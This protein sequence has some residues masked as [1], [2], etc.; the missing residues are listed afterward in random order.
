MSLP[1]DGLKEILE[2]MTPD[3]KAKLLENY[4]KFT[5]LRSLCEARGYIEALPGLQGIRVLKKTRE[6]RELKEVVDF[7]KPGHFKWLDK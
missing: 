5:K 1:L 7:L 4:S 3:F 6:V 2:K